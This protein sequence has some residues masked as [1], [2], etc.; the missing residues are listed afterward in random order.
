MDNPWGWAAPLD[1]D[2]HD[3]DH[4]DG[5]TGGGGAQ[6]EVPSAVTDGA[7]GGA[8]PPSRDR[9]WTVPSPYRHLD[10][11][12]L[13]AGCIPD[14]RLDGGIGGGS[15][16]GGEL[17]SGSVAAAAEGETWRACSCSSDDEDASRAPGDAAA[18]TAGKLSRAC[19][20]GEAHAAEPPPPP[21][22][23]AESAAAFLSSLQDRAGDG[24]HEG[25]Q[26]DGHH[27]G[28][29]TLVPKETGAWSSQGE[30]EDP[31]SDDLGEGSTGDIEAGTRGWEAVPGEERG[32][33]GRPSLPSPVRQSQEQ[34]RT[35]REEMELA[36][37]IAEVRLEGGGEGGSGGGGGAG[38][39]AEE[40]EERRVGSFLGMGRFEVGFGG[41]DA[42][43]EWVD[44]LDPGYMVMAVSEQELHH[45]QVTNPVL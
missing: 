3:D 14:F 9:S 16:R 30:R 32:T 17:G 8:T 21:A 31:P 18:R 45:G 10:D 12:P 26:D 4:D 43:D 41:G 25:L 38:G 37:A 7:P 35:A 44:D 5:A 23:A 19:A 29:Y 24:G 13:S 20:E 34:Q 2:D 6:G 28:V 27:G 36:A 11:K 1:H 15:G 39:H 22:V 42:E 40:E 33:G